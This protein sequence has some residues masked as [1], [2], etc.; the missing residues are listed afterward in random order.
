MVRRKE[1]WEFDLSGFGSIIILMMCVALFT[2]LLFM[3]VTVNPEYFA[4][5]FSV[6]I[7]IVIMWFWFC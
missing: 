3:A 5:A 7:F 4:H 1:Q 6:L 2:S